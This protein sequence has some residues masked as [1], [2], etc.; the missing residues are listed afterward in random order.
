MRRHLDACCHPHC[1][2]WYLRWILGH[3][4]TMA[5]EFFRHAQA[6]RVVLRIQVAPG[7]F[8]LA[9]RT[10]KATGKIT[11][12]QLPELLRFVLFQTTHAC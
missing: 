4:M 5:T 7:V 8:F 6:V 11:A 2:T 12:T 1:N 3:E 10:E 9:D